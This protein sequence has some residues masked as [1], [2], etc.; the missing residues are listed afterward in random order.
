MKKNSKQQCSSDIFKKC[1]SWTLSFNWLTFLN[2]KCSVGRK[3]KQ[4]W[5]FQETV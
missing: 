3:F 1:V 4:F 5:K 2:C